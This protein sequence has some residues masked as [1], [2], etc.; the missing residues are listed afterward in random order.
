MRDNRRIS[1]LKGGVSMRNKAKD[2]PYGNANKLEG[3]PRAKSEY[4]PIRADGSINTRPQE[5]MAASG[6]RNIKN[7]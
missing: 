6:S 7:R 1:L 5:R 4:A 3:E 2:F